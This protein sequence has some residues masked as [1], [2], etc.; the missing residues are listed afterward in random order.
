MAGSKA[1][2]TADKQ[3]IGVPFKPGQSGNP[4]GR[5]KGARAK[6][7]EAF[8]IDMQSAWKARGKDAIEAVID[9]KPDQFLKV[10]ASILPK[11]LSLDE[12]TTDALA[13]V[14]LQR[15]K[16]VVEAQRDAD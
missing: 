8:L 4:A 16:R 11:E 10:V 9:D 1:D 6:L 15:R 3:Q 14:I 13:D 12:E 2:L 5:P 7:G